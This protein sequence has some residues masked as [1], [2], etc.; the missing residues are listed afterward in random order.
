MSGQARVI[1]ARQAPTDM[2]AD[3]VYQPAGTGRV[4]GQI[5][6]WPASLR[7]TIYAFSRVSLAGD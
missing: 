5:A 7:V 1:S 2:G 6:Y 4:A 3:R